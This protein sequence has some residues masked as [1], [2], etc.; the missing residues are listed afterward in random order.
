MKTVITGRLTD[1][2]RAY[3]YIRILIPIT[4]AFIFETTILVQAITAADRMDG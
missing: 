4:S 1:N 2:L 3:F